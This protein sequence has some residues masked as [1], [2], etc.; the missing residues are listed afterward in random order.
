MPYEPPSGWIEPI[1]ATELEA[2]P[3]LGIFHRNQFCDRIKNRRQLR[4]TDKPYTAVRCSRCASEVT[5]TP[6][7]AP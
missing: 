6:I 3:R 7:G 4:P 2:D 1:P 5:P